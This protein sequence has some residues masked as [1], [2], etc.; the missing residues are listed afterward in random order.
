MTGGL[1]LPQQ[2]GFQ[3]WVGTSV[4]HQPGPL[5]LPK[6]R[7]KAQVFSR[8]SLMVRNSGGSQWREGVF[9]LASLHWSPLKSMDYKWLEVT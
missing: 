4:C 5:G 8:T 3:G 6:K 9:G 7:W 2:F 1:Q